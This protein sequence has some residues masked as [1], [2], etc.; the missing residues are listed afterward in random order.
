MGKKKRSTLPKDFREILDRGDIQEIRGVFES[1][2]VNAVGGYGKETAIAFDK[3][4]DE[5]V[6]WL[7]A[8]GADLSAKDTWGRSALH[9]R[10][11]SR[12]S[13]IAVLLELGANVSAIDSYGNTPLHSAAD[14]HHAGSAKLLLEHGAQINALNNEGLTPIELGLRSCRNIDI[15]HTVELVRILL[16]AGAKKSGSCLKSVETIGQAFEFHRE[17]FNKE[18]VEAVSSSLDQLY[19]ILGVPPI[20]RRLKYDGKSPI[21]PVSSSWQKQHEELWNLLVPSSGHASTIQGE[22]IRVSGRISNEIEGNGGA[23]WDADFSK[24]A[25]HFI[26]ILKHGAELSP[27][28]IEEAS[29]IVKS[30]RKL[31]GRSQRLAQLAVAWVVKN[32]TPLF[33]DKVAYKR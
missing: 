9:N 4:P 6:R 30:I 27:E 8:N 18:S 24:M 20:P 7:V 15:E 3:C 13:N 10:V 1:C 22:L 23:N 21:V 2:D 33:L 29:S 25:D 32:P 12:R 5:V 16:S 26:Q 19:E 17:G 31:D 11:G 14:S 28:E